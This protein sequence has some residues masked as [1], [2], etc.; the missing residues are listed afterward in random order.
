MVLTKDSEMGNHFVRNGSESV[1]QG[2]A[3]VPRQSG[4]GMAGGAGTQACLWIRCTF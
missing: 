4:Q 2:G 3:F 1:T